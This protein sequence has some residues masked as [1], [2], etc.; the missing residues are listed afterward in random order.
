MSVDTFAPIFI[1]EIDGQELSVD[2]SSH[3]ERFSYDDDEEKMDELRITI[4]DLDFSFIDNEQLQE[5]KEIKARWGY[6]GNM[7]EMKTC[8]IKEINYTFGNDRV[9]RIDITALDKGHKLTGRAARTCW[10][11]KKI[12][13]V[14]SD[15]ASKHNFTPKVNIK[16]DVQLE[17][18]SQGGK[19]DWVFLKEL[20]AETGCVFYVSNDELHF[21]PDE[22]SEP[23][24]KFT[25]GKDGDGYLQSFR[26]SLNAE[27]G[28][29]T[30]RATESAGLNP[31]S[32]KKIKET[33]KAESSGSSVRVVAL[34]DK[35]VSEN[36][37]GGG[38]LADNKVGSE[39]ALKAKDD[40]A[41][42]V[43]ATPANNAE[44]AKLAAQ[45]KVAKAAMQN[46]EAS[47]SIIGLPYLK[48]KDTITIE[49]LGGRFSGDWRIKKLTH[50]ISRSGYTCSLT[51]AKSNTGSGGGGSDKKPDAAPKTAKN[52]NAKPAD[53]KASNKKP[54]SRTVDL[55]KT[56]WK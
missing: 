26:I 44:T 34:G 30:A 15:I 18:L 7:S 2:I 33:S 35:P 11:N 4:C 10:S 8:T 25:W 1:I 13:D 14:V 27:K 36:N 20:A 56:G 12:A 52:N 5:G 23:V 21:E 24:R 40:E 39:T 48:A 43:K 38:A 29:G 9:A 55:S 41:G 31:L 46:L 53:N 19:S 54:P 28:K 17:F 42:R 51:L 45:G 37:K 22:V 16:E 50:S 49:N 32:K 47:A 3:I 6:L